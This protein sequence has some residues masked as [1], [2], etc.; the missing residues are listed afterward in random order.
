MFTDEVE[1]CGLNQ[2]SGSPNT[3]GKLDLA[4]NLVAGGRTGTWAVIRF[5]RLPHP[6]QNLS[7][8]IP[9]VRY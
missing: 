8:G 9:S 4:F 5:T 7:L 6:Q 2:Q 1:M 3:L